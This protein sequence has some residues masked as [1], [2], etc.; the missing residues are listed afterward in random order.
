[1][2]RRVVLL[3]MM[4]GCQP[5]TQPKSEP[6][7]APPRAETPVKETPP[8]PAKR[9]VLVRNM[10]PGACKVA[11]WAGPEMPGPE[12]TAIALSVGTTTIAMTKDEGLALQKVDGS[13]GS[14]AR[15]DGE[16]GEI[17]VYEHC[18]AIAAADQAFAA[19]G[20]AMMSLHTM[21]ACCEACEPKGCN[22]CDES[23]PGARCKAKEA[24]CAVVDDVVDCVP[25]SAVDAAGL[26]GGDYT[27]MKRMMAK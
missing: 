3:V 17:I 19:Q 6:A 14:W 5:A 23:K 1:M 16:N 11:V 10:G 22:G 18:G 25:A 4:A 15:T 21:A 7:A 9:D 27:M 2:G 13:Y 24:R 20:R 26:V 8:E 12:L